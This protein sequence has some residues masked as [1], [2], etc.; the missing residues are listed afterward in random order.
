[1][2]GSFLFLNRSNWSYR[3]VLQSELALKVGRESGQDRN[4]RLQHAY[5]L[6]EDLAGM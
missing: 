3:L 4:L 6:P 5:Y 2:K 1:M